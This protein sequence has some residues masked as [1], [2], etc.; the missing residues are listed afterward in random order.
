MRTEPTANRERKMQR[1][2]G[3]GLYRRPSCP[4]ARRYVWRSQ[5]RGDTDEQLPDE[6]ENDGSGSIKDFRKKMQTTEAKEGA[7]P[8]IQYAWN[9][10][11]VGPC[12]EKDVWWL[13]TVGQGQKGLGSPDHTCGETGDAGMPHS[14]ARLSQQGPSGRGVDFTG[15]HITEK[16][17]AMNL[18]TLLALHLHISTLTTTAH[19]LLH[20]S[21]TFLISDCLLQRIQ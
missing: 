7:D 9:E 4:R 5:V 11:S 1:R 13:M 16:R 17:H 20:M 2:N 10:G 3:N 8:W 15:K 6:E 18:T 12:A 14:A 21:T 19:L